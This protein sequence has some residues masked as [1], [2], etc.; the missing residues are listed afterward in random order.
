MKKINLLLIQ[1]IL[2]VVEVVDTVYRVLSD[3][4]VIKHQ[5]VHQALLHPPDD[6]LLAQDAGG[7]HGDVLEGEAVNISWFSPFLRFQPGLESCSGRSD[8]E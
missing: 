8:W 7:D 1:N 5:A 2:I 6:L 3:G 4:D